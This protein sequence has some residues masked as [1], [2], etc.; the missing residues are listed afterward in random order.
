MPKGRSRAIL[1]IACSPIVALARLGARTIAFFRGTTYLDRIG[2]V[3][4][5]RIVRYMNSAVPAG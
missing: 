2:P 1:G 4:E 5:R 3:G